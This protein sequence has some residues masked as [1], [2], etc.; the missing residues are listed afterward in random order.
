MKTTTLEHPN[1]TSVS[2]PKDSR[3]GL[4]FA[5]CMLCYGLA[6][7]VSTLLSVYL[8]VAVPELL[9]RSASEAELGRIGAYLNAAFVFGWMSGGLVAGVV[10]DRLGRVKTLALSAA[11]CGL[12]TWL[13]VWVTDWQTLLAYRFLA[14]TGVG[15]ILRSGSGR[16]CWPCP[17]WFS[18][19]YPNPGVGSTC[20]NIL[21]KQTSARSSPKTGR[22]CWSVRWCSARC[23]WVC[24]LFSRGCPRG[25]K[26]CSP[27]FRTG[28]GNAA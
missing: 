11:V 1:K 14:G 18:H 5:V 8:P 28:N 25:C 23:W 13:V 26:A 17:P 22:A 2:E 4:A 10:G 12:F 7:T 3:V 6:G 27:G 21:M 15:G 16:F 20:V 9:G 24:G 19:F